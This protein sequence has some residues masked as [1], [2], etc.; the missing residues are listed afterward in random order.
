MSKKKIESEDIKKHY[1]YLIINEEHFE[2]DVSGKETVFKKVKPSEVKKKIKL[3]EDLA[4]KL[5]DSLDG[6]A[7]MMEALSRMDI[8]ELESIHDKVFNIKKKVKIKTRSH[9]CVDMKVG[10]FIIPIVD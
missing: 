8:R 7:V 10:N 4:K 9:H 2:V 6:E 3:M 1:G 5:K